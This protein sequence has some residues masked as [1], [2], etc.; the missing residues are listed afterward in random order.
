MCPKKEAFPA[1]KKRGWSASA[2]GNARLAWLTVVPRQGG[3]AGRKKEG[4]A[5]E[6][7]TTPSGFRFP[8]SRALDH[9]PRGRP[10]DKG[11]GRSFRNI[12]EFQHFQGGRGWHTDSRL[13]MSCL[14]IDA[15][16][17]D[18]GPQKVAFSGAATLGELRRLIRRLPGLPSCAGHFH[19]CHDG[20]LLQADRSPLL[21]TALTL[22]LPNHLS[23]DS[24]P[25]PYPS[26]DHLPQDDEASL[27][28]LGVVDCPVV[29][30]L[31]AKGPEGKRAA[32]SQRPVRAG[33]TAGSTKEHPAASTAASSAAAAPSARPRAANDEA[34][35]VGA[36]AAPAAGAASAHG[37]RAAREVPA[38]AVCRIC[39][40]EGGAAAG[41]KCLPPPWQCR[42]SAPAPP[43]GT[44]GSVLCAAHGGRC[45]TSTA[46]RGSSVLPGR[47]LCH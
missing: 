42:S 14:V 34:A 20:S 46:A 40:S 24:S 12:L 38:D 5:P 33:A 39:F 15:A 4:D 47:V 21:L 2:G 11:G 16:L 41:S 25:D 10:G 30:I 1:G 18:A 9:D 26:P 29:V 37:G 27:A 7:R 13:R 3:D 19:V 31:A 6:E 45:T 35:P 44:P 8:T 17:K 32:V 43:R 28:S 36:T 23:S 22:T